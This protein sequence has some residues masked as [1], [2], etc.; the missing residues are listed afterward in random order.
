[1]ASAARGG[2]N[3]MFFNVRAER[4][5]F[6]NALMSV[7]KLCNLKSTSDDKETRSDA[8]FPS[9]PLS[10]LLSFCFLSHTETVQR[11]FE[12][13]YMTHLSSERTPERRFNFSVNIKV[14]VALKV[15]KIG[16]E[17]QPKTRGV[18]HVARQRARSGKEG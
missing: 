15:L 6:V 14:Y 7:M 3:E 4:I 16:V 11:I 5:L 8:G 18:E 13:L 12:L 2:G 17:M 1:M 9:L 10:L